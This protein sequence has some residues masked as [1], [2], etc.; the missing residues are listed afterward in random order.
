MNNGKDLVLVDVRSPA[1]YNEMRIKDERVRLIPLGKLRS[2][3]SELPKDKKMVAFCK[4]SLR[5]YEASTILSGG[6]VKDVAFMDGGLIMWPFEVD[7]SPL[8]GS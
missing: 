7:T 4:T 6:G 2:V 5:G 3:L 8:P 1:E